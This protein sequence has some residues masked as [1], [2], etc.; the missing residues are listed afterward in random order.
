MWLSQAV[1]SKEVFQ[2]E[3]F[4]VVLLPLMPVLQRMRMSHVLLETQNTPN[5][6]NMQ[7]HPAPLT[8]FHSQPHL[9]PALGVCQSSFIRDPAAALLLLLAAALPRCQ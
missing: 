3:L 7:M 9:P 6:E 4:Q 2:K 1:G 5:G 8:P